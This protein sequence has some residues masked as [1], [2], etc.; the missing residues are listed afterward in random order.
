MS[1]HLFKIELSLILEQARTFPCYWS[2][3]SHP[4]SKQELSHVRQGGTSEVVISAECGV[5]LSY[6]II[7]YAVER[8]TIVVGVAMAK[9]A[10]I[11]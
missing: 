2:Q 11:V 4:L 8:L 5:L 3:L 9:E 7:Y 10:I 6:V 1:K